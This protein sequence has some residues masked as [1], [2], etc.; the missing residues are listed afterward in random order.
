ME[1]SYTK[2][3]F[4]FDLLLWRVQKGENKYTYIDD[5]DQTLLPF[6]FVN[7]AIGNFPSQWNNKQTISLMIMNWPTLNA[8]QPDLSSFVCWKHK[9]MCKFVNR[10]N[11]VKPC[12]YLMYFLKQSKCVNI[13]SLQTSKMLN[14][15]KS[16]FYLYNHS[17]H[18]TR[19]KQ[20]KET[21]YYCLF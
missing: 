18:R 21:Y 3:P 16:L 7:V 15:Q 5:D 20:N 12:I 10:F 11:N 2:L 9:K 17:I 13:I 1:S 19:D 6:A 4:D 14:Q 8:Y